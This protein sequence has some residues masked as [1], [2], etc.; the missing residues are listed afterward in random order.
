MLAAGDGAMLVV[1]AVS[2]I[3]DLLEACLQAP[4]DF[5]PDATLAEVRR[6]HT[7]LAAATGADAG[8]LEPLLAQLHTELAQLNPWGRTSNRAGTMGRS[9]G[10]R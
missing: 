4:A 6:R 1:S 9:A 7:M 2:G 8:I 3:T 10:L 5:D